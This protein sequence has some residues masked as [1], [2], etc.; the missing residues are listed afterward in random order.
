MR[1]KRWT[2]GFIAFF[3]ALL[4]GFVVAN[5]WNK[6]GPTLAEPDINDSPKIV[7]NDPTFEEPKAPAD[8]FI[9]EFRDL[10]NF[11]DI[12]YIK[13]PGKLIELLDDG[14][15]RR[16][17]VVAKNGESWMVL[18]DNGGELSVYPRKAKVKKLS[19][20][21]WPGEERDA[22]LSFD[23]SGKPFFA[24][25]NLNTVKKGPVT[26]LFHLKRW[27]ENEDGSPDFV[28]ISDGFRREFTIGARTYILRTSRG[29]TMDHTKVAVLLLESEGT[30]Q[31]LK[32]IRHF[33][34]DRDIFGSLLWVGDMDGDGKLDLYFDEFNE[35]GYTATE[36]HLST[37]AEPGKLVGLAADFGMAGC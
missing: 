26:T 2:I 8:D 19:S 16:S 29:I 33:G 1:L 28:E 11:E 35:K 18:I 21:S 30:T 32:Q 25:K 10:P 6:P 7:V 20:V 3:A 34:G 4:I 22:K 27:A 15:Y 31:I 17:E 23:H 5:T 13:P 36:L 24:I 14:I 12:K 37:Q 9:A